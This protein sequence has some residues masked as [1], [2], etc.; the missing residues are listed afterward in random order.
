MVHYCQSIIGMV[1][2]PLQSIIAVNIHRF[3]YQDKLTDG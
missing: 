1:N 2:G 3:L